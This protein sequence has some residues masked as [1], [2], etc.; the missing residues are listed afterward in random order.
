MKKT[1]LTLALTAFVAGTIFTGCSSPEQKVQN[2][3]DKVVQANA[4][5]TKANADLNK[6]EDDYSADMAMFRKESDER[7]AANEKGIADFEAR[8]AKEKKVARDDYR[9]KISEL[10]QKDTDMKK[11]LDDYRAEGKDKWLAFKTDFNTG[12]DDIGKSLNDLTKSMK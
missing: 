7:I 2:A 6:A 12:M 11:R 3:Q 5:V 10:Q 8:I 1:I 9:K 4:D